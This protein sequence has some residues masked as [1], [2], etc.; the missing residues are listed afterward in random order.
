MF[1][2]QPFALFDH[3][4]SL[5]IVE[6]KVLNPACFGSWA[7]FKV[8]CNLLIITFMN[9]LYRTGSSKMSR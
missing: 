3:C 4:D 7:S 1:I 8:D 6:Y 5:S 2:L 9:I